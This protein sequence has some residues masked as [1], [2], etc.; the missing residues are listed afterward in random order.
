MGCKVV[1]GETRHQFGVAV[2]VDHRA[3]LNRPLVLR[4]YFPAVAQTHTR[5]LHGRGPRRVV[6]VNHRVQ[7]L[8]P[9]SLAVFRSRGAGHSTRPSRHVRHFRPDLPTAVRAHMGT[10][11]LDRRA[12]GGDRMAIHPYLPRQELLPPALL[13]LSFHVPEAPRMP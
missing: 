5:A 10:F 4:Q 13:T 11:H 1:L 3:V 12:K 8:N 6:A 7:G 2:L 9:T